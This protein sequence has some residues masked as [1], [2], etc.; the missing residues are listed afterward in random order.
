MC[1]GNSAL[2][3]EP[4][5]R[6]CSS[7]CTSDTKSDD[8]NLVLDACPFYTGDHAKHIVCNNPNAKIVMIL[9]DPYDRLVSV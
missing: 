1:L 2:M 4:G 9:R 8:N 6:Q 5:I 7:T 3:K